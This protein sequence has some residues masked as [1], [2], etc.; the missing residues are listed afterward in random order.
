MKLCRFPLAGL[1]LVTLGAIACTPA[2]RTEPQPSSTASPTSTRFLPTPMPRRYRDFPDCVSKVSS[3][4]EYDLEVEIIEVSTDE[5][6]VNVSGY[7]RVFNEVIE[8]CG[9][10][11]DEDRSTVSCLKKS[12]ISPSSFVHVFDIEK[13]SR[14][15]YDYEIEGYDE[16]WES[17]VDECY[18]EP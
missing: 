3:G 8:E 18:H 1:V 9:G 10:F 4:G 17:L 7:G 6:E 12:R 5:F 11:A 13:N 2:S 15:H 14:G 16:W